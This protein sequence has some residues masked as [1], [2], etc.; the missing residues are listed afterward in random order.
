MTNIFDQFKSNV[1]SNVTKLNEEFSRLLSSIEEIRRQ[2]AEELAKYIAIKNVVSDLKKDEEKITSELNKRELDIAFREDEIKRAEERSAKELIENKDKLKE[3]ILTRDNVSNELSNLR[4]EVKNI[5]PL[6]AIKLGLEKSIKELVEKEQE[7]RDVVNKII[8]NG[9]EELKKIQD[10]I[11]VEEDKL[12]KLKSENEE[13]LNK[14]QPRIDFINSKEKEL[15][16]KEQAF[17]VLETRYKKMFGDQGISI[18]I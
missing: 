2:E 7:Q 1:L 11:K 4:N 9:N 6:E 17:I 18:K 13:E 5:K 10:L 16:D 14:L 8:S 15:K 12:K 3:V